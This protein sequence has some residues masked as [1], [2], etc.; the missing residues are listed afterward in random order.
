MSVADFVPDQIST[1]DQVPGCSRELTAK[2][3]KNAKRHQRNKLSR[4]RKRQQLCPDC[5]DVDSE[6]YLVNMKISECKHSKIAKV[7]RIRSTAA[8]LKETLKRKH[9]TCIDTTT[10]KIVIYLFNEDVEFSEG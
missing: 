8:K 10:T 7:N 3:R 2:Q 1:A 6:G 5:L 4:L 9:I